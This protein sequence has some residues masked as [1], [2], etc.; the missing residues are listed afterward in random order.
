MRG[1]RVWGQQVRLRPGVRSLIDL[2]NTGDT[3]KTGFTKLA[4][5]TVA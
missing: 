2:E 1:Q 4:E 3:R 5:G